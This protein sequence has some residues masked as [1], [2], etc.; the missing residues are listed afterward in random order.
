[1][2]DVGYLCM[3][4]GEGGIGMGRPPYF[5]DPKGHVE[6]IG[7]FRCHAVGGYV[8]GTI[9]LCNLSG[10]EKLKETAT[11]LVSFTQQNL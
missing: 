11:I 5:F 8:E 10:E 7:F 1:M 4:L 3:L 9:F 2:G 6:G